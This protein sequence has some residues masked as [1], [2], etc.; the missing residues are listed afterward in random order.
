MKKSIY[1]TLLVS[2]AAI[3]FSIGFSIDSSPAADG[4]KITVAYGANVMGY[5]EPC[6]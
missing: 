3:L 6:G 1:L 5:L 4:S 2:S